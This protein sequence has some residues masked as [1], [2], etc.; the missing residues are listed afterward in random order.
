VEAAHF[1]R[2]SLFFQK[3]FADEV[4]Q[5]AIGDFERFG[6]SGLIA[7]FDRLAYRFDDVFHA[8]TV[9]AIALGAF[10]RLSDPFFG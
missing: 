1:A 4:M 8:G 6:R 3:A 2:R 5:L 7:R 10:D 9:I